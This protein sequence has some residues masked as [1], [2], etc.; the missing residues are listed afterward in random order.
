MVTAFGRDEVREEAERLGI[1]GFLVKPVTKSMLV[2][3]LVTLFA[4]A[5]GETAQAAS[6]DPHAGRLTRRAHPAGRGQRDQPADRGG[7]A[8]RRRR[9]A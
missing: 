7:A 1:D 9:H 6:D 3:T 5:A 4:P 2:D 8:G